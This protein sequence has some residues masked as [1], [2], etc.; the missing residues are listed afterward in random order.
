M[1]LICP[2][3]KAVYDV[4]EQ[5]LGA[6]PRRVRCTRCTYEWTQPP[7]Q[8]AVAPP[9]PDPPPLMGEMRDIPAERFPDYEEAAPTW[10]RPAIAAW[11][12]SILLLVGLVVAA[13]QFRA[14]VMHGWPPSQR[15]YAMFG[16]V[17]R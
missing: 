4:P 12:A 9:P 1:R 6:G 13:V 3:C 8:A 16:A 11:A 15:L 2:T 7:V 10:D 17:P 14:E 5:R